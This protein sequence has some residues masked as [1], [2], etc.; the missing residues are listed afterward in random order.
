MTIYLKTLL[1]FS[2]F[3][4][5]FTVHLQS[6]TIVEPVAAKKHRST[7]VEDVMQYISSMSPRIASSSADNSSG[8]RGVCPGHMSLASILVDAVKTGGDV[9]RT[10]GSPVMTLKE[11]IDARFRSGYCR[12]HLHYNAPSVGDDH[13]RLDAHTFESQNST[14]TNQ[15]RNEVRFRFCKPRNTVCVFFVSTFV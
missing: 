6:R 2:Y 3:L 1:T 12:E 15:V 8:D 5:Y 13:N 7:C 9:V 4:T 10:F 11:T 14:A